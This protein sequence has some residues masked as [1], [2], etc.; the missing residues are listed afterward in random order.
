M[1]IIETH[2]CLRITHLS[3]ISFC[4]VL[5]GVMIFRAREFQLIIHIMIVYVFLSSLLMQIILVLLILVLSYEWRD[6]GKFNV[7]NV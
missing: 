4:V 7:L 1:L 3:F 5:I 2:Y 6:V